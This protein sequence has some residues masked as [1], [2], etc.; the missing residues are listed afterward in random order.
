[1]ERFKAIWITRNEGEKKQNPAENREISLDDL[2][3]GD[4]TVRVSYTTMNY[5]D[6]L[7]ITGR[8]PVVRTFPMIPGIDLAGEVVASDSAKF[9]PG[10]KVLLNGFGVGET[11]MGAYAGMARLSSDWLIPLPAGPERLAGDGDRHR[12]LY[13]YALRHG[14]G[15]RRP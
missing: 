6:A 3:P 12:R 13:R 11:H 10:D 5:K 8:N 9:K 14:A 4:V 7:A 15:A 1:M 2:M